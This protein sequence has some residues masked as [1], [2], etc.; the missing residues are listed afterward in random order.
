[1]AEVTYR[2]GE[3]VTV[4]YTPSSGNV[5][6]GQVVLVGNTTGWTCGIAVRDI[7]NSTLGTLAAGGGVYDVVNLNNAANGTKVYWDDTNN[8]VTTTSTNNA[9]FGFIVA[10]GGG[11]ANTTARA[12]HFPYV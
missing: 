10:D 2:Y 9:L 4:D 6:A 8:K 3:P 12:L 7:T 1:M 5:S 11:G